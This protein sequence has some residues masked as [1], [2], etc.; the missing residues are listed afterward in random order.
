ME[1]CLACEAEGVATRGALPYRRLAWPLTW[2]GARPR[3]PRTGL[4][5]GVR[6][7]L[8]LLCTA[9]REPLIAGTR[10]LPRSQARPRSKGGDRYSG[11][12]SLPGRKRGRAPRAAAATAYRRLTWPLTWEGARPRALRQVCVVELGKRSVCSVPPSANH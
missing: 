6:K 12:R 4:R 10:S 3:A 5:R 8:D 7:T 1:R 2:E 11:T 9:L